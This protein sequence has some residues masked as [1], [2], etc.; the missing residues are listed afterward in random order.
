MDRFITGG[1]GGS[2]FSLGALAAIAEVSP[3]LVEIGAEG[4]SWWEL[5]DLGGS[6]QMNSRRRSRELCALCK[7]GEA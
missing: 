7:E 2:I 1:A 3:P 5:A 4:K 6:A